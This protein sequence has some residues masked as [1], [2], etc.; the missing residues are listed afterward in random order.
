MTLATVSLWALGAY[1]VMLLV[2][3]EVRAARGAT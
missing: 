3:A 2:V 1:L